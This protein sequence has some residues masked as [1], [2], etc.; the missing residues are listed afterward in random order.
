MQFG[1]ISL[2]RR[3]L[4]GLG[5]NPQDKI[6]PDKIPRRTHLGNSIVFNLWINNCLFVDFF[7]SD[8]ANRIHDIQE[9]LQDTQSRHGYMARRFR[10]TND[11]IRKTNA[12]AGIRLDC[13][14]QNLIYRNVFSHCSLSVFMQTQIHEKYYF[15]NIFLE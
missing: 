1:M 11:L 4:G 6:T 14:C 8:F 7:I 3:N 5:P 9:E 2:K 10:T 13:K 15:R 12:F